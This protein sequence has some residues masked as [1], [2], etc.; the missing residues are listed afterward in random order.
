MR[1]SVDIAGH[2]TVHSAE[3]PDMLKGAAEQAVA[4]WVFRRSAIDRVHLIATFKYGADRS[5]AK[6]E[7]VTQ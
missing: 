2:V 7:R 1:F 4:T 3:G 6:V 5:F